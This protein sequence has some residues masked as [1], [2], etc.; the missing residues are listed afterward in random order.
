M[1]IEHNLEALRI[2]ITDEERYQWQDG[3]A[4]FYKMGEGKPPW[5]PH[6]DFGDDSDATTKLRDIIYEFPEVPQEVIEAIDTLKQLED[7]RN[8]YARH[9]LFVVLKAK[10][11]LCP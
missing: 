5:N 1:K 3:L 11:E 7:I 2:E 4:F 9:A 8:Q 6:D 10:K